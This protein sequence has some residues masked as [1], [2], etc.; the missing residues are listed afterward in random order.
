MKINGDVYYAHR[1]AWLYHYGEWTLGPIN[2]IDEGRTNNAIENLRLSAP[3][4]NAARRKTIRTIGT[5]RGVF[6][7]GPGF[8]AR[9]HHHN[10]RHYLGYFKT[11]EE[12]KAAY[13]AKA[14]EI[15]GEFAYPPEA[16]VAH[17][18]KHYQAGTC[19]GLLGFGA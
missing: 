2:H 17:L 6:P 19:A 14:K 16:S 10:K 7:H 12:A 18:K 9:I 4:Q 11:A 3:A 1:V 13:E 5:S 8:V 15:H